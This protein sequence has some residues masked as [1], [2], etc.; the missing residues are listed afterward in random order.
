[1]TE[2]D[3]SEELI[4]LPLGGTGEI[5]MNLNLYGYDGQWLMV[6]LGVSFSDDVASGIDVIMADPAFIEE[7]QRAL[8]G[9]VVTHGHEDHI[10][11][12]AYLWNRLRC[13]IWASPFT[14]SLLRSKLNEAGILDDVP[15][16]VVSPGE[17]FQVGP[18]SLE[19]VGMTHS[20]P[21][22]NSLLIRTPLGNVFHTGDWKFDPTPLIG[23]PVDMDALQRIGDEG[24]LAVVGDSTN[25]FS[26][27]ETRSEADVRSSLR[28]LL[29]V[30]DGKIAVACFATNVARVESIALAAQAHNR[31][32]VLVGRSLWR[33]E[34]AARENGY[35]QDI[36]PFLTEHDVAT[37]KPQNSVYICT[38]S[39]G[40]PNAALARIASGGHPRVTLGKGDVTI[41]SSRIIP[42]NEKAIGK[43]QNQL[44]ER[45]VEI[46]TEHDRFVHVSGHPGRPE[47]MKM[48]GLLRPRYAV[49]VHGEAR[50]LMAHADL[51][52]SCGVSK[53]FQ[54]RNGMM[55]RL[56]PGE[57][58]VVAEV[59]TGCIALD[60][61][62][63]IKMDSATLRDRRKMFY[64]GTVVVTVVVDAHGLPLCPPQVSAPGLLNAEEE[65]AEH[66]TLVDEITRALDR[67]SAS[68]R[69]NDD[70]VREAARL[71]VRRTVKARRGK[72]PLT[73]I[74]LVR[75]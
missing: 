1:M 39:Q 15:L 64:G 65:V 72:K 22:A 46:V 38:G 59:P 19:Y 5:G 56:A 18:F 71:A 66:Q 29:G 30:Y 42:G 12:I 53:A 74:H 51:A 49:P 17:R 25:V 11:A 48:Y 41:F 23:S 40:E 26:K 63:L 4:F 16:T 20:I 52:E 73:D 9:L 62:A 44:I 27:R 28:D 7:R 2:R 43:I 75:I 14:A 57:P 13:P 10:G 37:L 60:G 47:L 70:S 3:S 35:L 36:P 55:L 34:K 8:S 61:S 67:L 31:R 54:I 68:Q 45:G 24:V 33:L 50:H 6:D 21:E 58:E 69:R 32:T